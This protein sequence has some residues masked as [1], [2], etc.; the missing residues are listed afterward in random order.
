MKQIDGYLL[1]RKIIPGKTECRQLMWILLLS[2]LIALTACGS[3]GS[4]D[5]TSSE[6]VN[7]GP[8]VGRWIQ[9]NFLSKDD[10]GVFDSDDLSGIGFVADIT[11]TH[12]TE[13]D[14]FG[15]GCA[16]TF[17]YKVKADMTYTKNAVSK[18]DLCP[19]GL[20]LSLLSD[21]GRLVFSQE[22]RFMIEYFDTQPGDDI[23][24]FKWMRE[25]GEETDSEMFSQSR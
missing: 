25:P 17:T 12:W 1:R 8:W 7:D 19:A 24:A 2:A 11:K 15:E 6:T 9:V 22:N 10:N 21:S 3:S 13:T 4:D 16:V 23:V 14:D 18:N 5:D 20:S